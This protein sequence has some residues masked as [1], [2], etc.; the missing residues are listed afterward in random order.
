MKKVEKKVE[1]KKKE[2]KTYICTDFKGF[3][4]VGTA[5]VIVAKDRRAAESALRDALTL[6]GIQQALDWKPTLDM[7]DTRFPSVDILLDGDY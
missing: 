7:V 6:Q 5:A 3:N 1:K 4:P 2:L